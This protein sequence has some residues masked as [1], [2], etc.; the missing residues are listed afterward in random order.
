MPDVDGSKVFF[1]TFGNLD[2]KSRL[3]LQLLAG[4]FEVYHPPLTNFDNSS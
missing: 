1:T 4:N 2:Q 3:W